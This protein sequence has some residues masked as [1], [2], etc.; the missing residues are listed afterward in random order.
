V[1]DEEGGA[2]F[3]AK[4]KHKVWLKT[5]ESLGVCRKR[6]LLRKTRTGKVSGTVFTPRGGRR[7]VNTVPSARVP[8]WILASRVAL[9]AE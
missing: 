9:V 4:K 7:G 2:K 8:L 5:V 1:R 3:A 6:G